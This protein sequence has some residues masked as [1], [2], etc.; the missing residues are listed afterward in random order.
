MSDVNSVSTR[1]ISVTA[2][3]NM[4]KRRISVTAKSC[5]VPY[6]DVSPSK[7]RLHRR[8]LSASQHKLSAKATASPVF[9]VPDVEQEGANS[10]DP[11]C[12]DGP[13]C[14][15]FSEQHMSSY[16]ER[17][18]KAADHWCEVREPL[19]NA[20]VEMSG[21]PYSGVTCVVCDHTATAV[22]YDCGPQAFFC[23]EHIEVFHSSKINTF[24]MPQISKVW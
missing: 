21:F 22:C 23:D 15:D 16:N 4:S 7:K 20:A 24:H 2:K 14:F 19:L 5:S 13:L 10:S 9:S 6:L 1:R 18:Q 11:P 8:T 12:D 3:H 17:Q